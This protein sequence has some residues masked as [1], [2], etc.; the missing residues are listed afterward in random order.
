MQKSGRVHRTVALLATAGSMIAAM[1]P[2]AA[3]AQESEAA[4]VPDGGL[5]A[6]VVTANRRS[7]N[8]QDVPIS[9]IA[10]EGQELAGQGITNITDLGHIVPGLSVSNAVG[11]GIT[12]LRGVGSSAIGPGIETPISIYL[13]GIYYA[14]SVA[15][16]F[17]LVNIDRVEVLKGP[18]GTLFGRNATGGLIQ[19]FTRDP[20]QDTRVMG[21]VSYGNYD[22]FSG[23][24]YASTPLTENLAA[25]IMVRASAMG[26]GY[27]TNLVN[28]D[29]VLRNNHNIALRSKWVWDPGADTRFT[30]IGDFT[31]SENSFNAGRIPS[32]QTPPRGVPIYG[33]SVWDTSN[34]RTPSLSNRNWGVSLKVDQSLGF[35][36]LSNIVS[37]RDS[38]TYNIFDVDFTSVPY[39]N[40]DPLVQDETQFS[41]ELR[42][43]SE[44][45]GPLTWQTG[46]FYFRARGKY[47]P[48]RAVF[49]NTDP[50]LNPVFPLGAI[51]T[52]GNQLTESIAVYGQGTY[53]LGPDTN[54]TLGARYTYEQRTI[55]G[56]DEGELLDGT[57]IGILADY[58]ERSL[59]F[60][61]PTIRVALDHRLSPE[62]MVFASFNTGFKSGGFNTQTPGAD[63]FE[64]ETLQAWEA[65]FKSDLLD[66]RLRF[67]VNAYHY[68]YRNVQ[69]QKVVFAA[70]GIINGASAHIT[71]LEAEL[72]ALIGRGFTLNANASITDANYDDFPIA[73]RSNPAGGVNLFAA[74]ASGNVIPKSPGFQG[75][76]SADYVFDLGGGEMALNAFYSYNSGFF[77][78][79]DNV[80]RQDDFSRVNL[81]AT[82]ASPGGQYSIRGWVRNLTN[83]KVLGYAVSLPDGTREAQYEP[84][85]TY[86]VTLGFEF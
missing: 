4:T 61:K 55:V 15:A 25:D 51:I 47:D 18:Q 17:D 44:G 52:Y 9:V 69:V 78:E 46:V 5:D 16:Q 81:S 71:G 36:E 58:P 11:F 7:E 59:S 33:G 43:A 6:I 65:G 26:D 22:S 56:R 38:L 37:Y 3:F 48:N 85:R 23:D 31:D 42:L 53:A 68:D 60:E 49:P 77:L 27:G 79:A 70:T 72:S 45:S 13:D 64:P 76:L 34:D 39:L 1:S 62:F 41:E 10:I 84:P 74:P 73:P 86:G 40:G 32:D 54:L 57:S 20:G 35:A 66:R 19:V 82:W 12:T 80:Y 2:G 29:D 63:P 30:L 24:L 28:G 67:N 75:V 50:A 8:L 21:Q 83:A 14:S